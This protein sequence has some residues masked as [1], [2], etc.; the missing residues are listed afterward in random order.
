MRDP[1]AAGFDNGNGWPLDDV[2]GAQDDNSSS[3]LATT[4][5]LAL[6]G[7]APSN[8]SGVISECTETPGF[9]EAAGTFLSLFPQSKV[10]RPLSNGV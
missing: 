7:D 2:I 8:R 3:L 1:T 10:V 9:L 4:M 5:P 6:I